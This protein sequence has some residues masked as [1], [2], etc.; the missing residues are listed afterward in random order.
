MPGVIGLVIENN[1]GTCRMV[2]G[3]P[4]HQ[5]EAGL[6]TILVQYRLTACIGGLNLNS[7]LDMPQNN[8]ACEGRPS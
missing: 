2:Y 7:D 1:R 4:G 5:G 6:Q 8:A 3:V